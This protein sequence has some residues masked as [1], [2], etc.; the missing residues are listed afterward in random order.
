MAVIKMRLQK[1]S[2]LDSWTE[3]IFSRDA[4][5]YWLGSGS[6]IGELQSTLSVSRGILN[7][8]RP[9]PFL[10]GELI[11]LTGCFNFYRSGVQ[12]KRDSFVYSPSRLVLLA[13]LTDFYASSDELAEKNFAHTDA[14][15]WNVAHTQP[16]EARKLQYVAYRP[17]DVRCLY[18]HVAF[19]DRPRPDLQAV[20]GDQNT[21][22]YA[23]PAG[24]G[25]GPAVWC[26]GLLPDYHSFRGSYGGYAFPLFDRRPNVAASNVSSALIASLSA[27]YGEQVAAEDVFDTILCLLSASSYSLRFAEDLEDVFPHIPFP[28]T[29][30][31]FQDAVKLGREIRSVETFARQPAA[32]YRRPDFVRV[33]T[34]PRGQVAPVDYAD[35]EITLCA[36]GSGRITGLPLGVWRFAVSGYRVLPRW[37]EARIALPADLAFVRELRDICGRIAELIDLFDEA[38]TVLDATLRET[39]SREALEFGE[40]E[41]TI[42]DE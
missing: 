6:E 22:M 21:C 35:G 37:L 11:G 38:D 40:P 36:D 41:P 9:K 14:R 3:G 24:T 19:I 34:D 23:M 4:K 10:N 33:V 28:A 12:T 18:N 16:V 17:F 32:D 7:D 20:W 42:D 25:A 39:L 15:P 5:L 13:R 27:A 26:H 29:H 30:E 31:I 8:F 1:F 2:Y